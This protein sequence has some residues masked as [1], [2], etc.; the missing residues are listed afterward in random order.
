MLIAQA[1]DPSWHIGAGWQIVGWVLGL[2]WTLLQISGWFRKMRQEKARANDIAQAKHDAEV[3]AKA[4]ATEVAKVQHA[5]VD[6]LKRGQAEGKE[7]TREASQKIQE[8]LASQAESFQLHCDD[9]TKRFAEFGKRLDGQ[10]KISADHGKL[11]KQI[12]SDV[13]AIKVTN[14]KPKP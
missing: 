9:D 1:A 11:L 7:A 5:D 4:I 2:L 12:A 13:K 10:D 3:A 14:S 6:E 8:S